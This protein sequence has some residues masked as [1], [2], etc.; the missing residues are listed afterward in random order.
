MP[1]HTLVGATRVAIH[2]PESIL[3]AGLVSYLQHDREL[4]EVPVGDVC[5][6]D[7]VVV[8]PDVADAS[9]L[10]DLGGLSG[11]A[12][13]SFVLVVARGQWRADISSAVEHG[14][15]AVLW[16]DSFTPDD[17]TRILLTVARGGGSFPVSLQGALMEQVQITQREVLVPRGLATSGISFREADVLRLVAEGQELSQIAAKLSY[18]ESTIKYVLYGVMKRLHLRNRA[19][20]VSYAIRSGLI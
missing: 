8:A 14:V 10:E 18:S 17:F 3:R 4:R 9:M 12:D 20:A 5:D 16:R 11:V 13:I 7:V 1:V 19:H 2:A 6:G 15:R